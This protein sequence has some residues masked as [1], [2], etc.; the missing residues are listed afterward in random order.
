MPEEKESNLKTMIDKTSGA[1]SG[2][3]LMTEN[4]DIGLSSSKVS[5]LVGLETP[6]LRCDYSDKV[7]S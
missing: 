6:E 1:S 2:L 7:P 4:L 5:S 3:T